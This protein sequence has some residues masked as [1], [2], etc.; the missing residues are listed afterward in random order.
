MTL[1]P[2]SPEPG[3][4]ARPTGRSLTALHPGQAAAIL[5]LLLADAILLGA[6][7]VLPAITVTQ[8][9]MFDSDVSILGS[10]RALRDEGNL[11][12]AA[13]ILLFSVVLPYLKLLLL[14]WLMLWHG[15]GARRHRLL[16][17]IG[18]LGKWS[19]LDVLALALV[20]VT[21]R[22]GFWVSASLQS[23]LYL[24]AGAVVLAMLLT[25]W[26]IRLAARNDEDAPPPAGR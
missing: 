8:L 23:G 18:G 20:V 13:V 3:P 25:G 17:A 7:L 10:V 4:A 26:V 6:G 12:L 16:R 15:S 2:S 21:M 24:F 14:A 1:V 11:L 22:Q 5:L 9:G 19:M